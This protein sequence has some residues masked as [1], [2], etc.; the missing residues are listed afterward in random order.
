MRTLWLCTALI[1]MTRIGSSQT[2]DSSFASW[3]RQKSDTSRASQTTI[4]SILQPAFVPNALARV[5]AEIDSAVAAKCKNAAPAPIPPSPTPSPPL[6]PPPPAPVGFPKIGVAEVPDGAAMP[7]RVRPPVARGIFVS[8]CASIQPT[9]D[10]ARLGDDIQIALS[11]SPCRGPFR[12]KRGGIVLRTAGIPWSR[13]RRF[14]PSID[15]AAVVR[16]E[17]SA[18][19][20]P[21]LDVAP[22]TRDVWIEALE[23]AQ[24]AA[25]TSSN[26]LVTLG[27][28]NAPPADTLSGGISLVGVWVHG[29]ANLATSVQRCVAIRTDRA[30]I[31]DSWIEHCQKVMQDAQAIYIASGARGVWIENT[32]AFGAGQSVFS[33]ADRSPGHSPSDIILDGVHMGMERALCTALSSQITRKTVLELK[34]AKR[35]YGQRLV[36]DGSCLV[37]VYGQGGYGILLKT[38]GD[39]GGGPGSCRYC[40]T[41]DVTL[42]DIL[43]RN[44]GAGITVSSTEA[45]PT[46]S[47]TSRIVFSNVALVDS[48]NIA[49]WKGDGRLI[50][51]NHREAALSQIEFRNV[52]AVDQSGS[53]THFVLIDNQGRQIP[54]L[55]FMDV[56][57]KLGT[58]GLWTPSGMGLAGWNAVQ[59]GGTWTAVALQG[60]TSTPYPLG[61][62]FGTVG[63][64]AGTDV[65]ALRNRLN[66]V[67]VP[68]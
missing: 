28:Y 30:Y 56:G 15:S 60:S 53:P 54:R 35:F 46:D 4:A 3:V 61:T 26:A 17:A 62:T 45:G 63:A 1:L 47:S 7:T 55:V 64:T 41:S 14:R 22:G 27:D 18:N 19:G 20:T 11:A 24:P 42:S 57:S 5:T 32:T 12:A 37:S 16:L 58:Y 49:P 13:G 67:V 68:R 29:Q 59:T 36:I 40:Q 25:V 44:V 10:T 6:P 23:L 51:L 34:A 31:A 66:G 48:F 9:L 65:A 38:V 8:S 50:L 39:R 43:I 33:D 2:C 21:L 52:R